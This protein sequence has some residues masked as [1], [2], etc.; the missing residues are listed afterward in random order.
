MSKPV[1][2]G[3]NP[4]SESSNSPEKRELPSSSPLARQLAQPSFSS[5]SQSELSQPVPRSY[6]FSRKTLVGSNISTP[7][8]PAKIGFRE[9]V[10]S[11][12]R[13]A[14]SS[15]RG[16]RRDSTT[17]NIENGWLDIEQNDQK[18][19]ESSKKEKSDDSFGFLN[20]SSSDSSSGSDSPAASAPNAKSKSLEEQSSSSSS[21]S[22][23]R[24]PVPPA[25][26]SNEIA[27]GKQEIKG[28]FQLPPPLSHNTIVDPFL[29]LPPPLASALPSFPSSSSSSSSLGSPVDAVKDENHFELDELHLDDLV[30]D[31]LEPSSNQECALIKAFACIRRN[32]KNEGLFRV[33]GSL[34]TRQIYLTEMQKSRSL[35]EVGDFGDND[36]HL[37]TDVIK[38]LM[39]N[40]PSKEF[41]AY[42]QHN[43]QYDDYTR[44]KNIIENQGAS[45]KER[46]QKVRSKLEQL[47]PDP[48]QVLY[49]K[50][51]L[52]LL[53]EISEHSDV[54]Q[55]NPTNLAIS[56]LTRLLQINVKNPSQLVELMM[57]HSVG[58]F[59]IENA[60]ELFQDI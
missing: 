18:A 22:S 21:S 14:F 15:I 59:L 39:G 4:P 56:I 43:I 11:G 30:F 9:S 1:G 51:F 25:P 58:I 36:I 3:V 53:K 44:L 48:K 32:L 17:D 29:Q 10:L 54:N 57:A 33:G 38:V 16:D 37:A 27:E 24:S 13:S 55:M 28:L 5:F 35:S 47:I 8:Q 34:D 49:F 26:V 23:S 19:F 50:A 6:T 60:R 7:N 52:H 42:F 12:V 20:L 45:I 46:V 40:V 31:A 41:P 2:Q